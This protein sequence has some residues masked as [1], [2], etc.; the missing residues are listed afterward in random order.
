M[1]NLGCP[2]NGRDNGRDNGG[3]R[4]IEVR[5]REVPLYTSV[6]LVKVLVIVVNK[7]SFSYIHDVQCY[8][9]MV[10]LVLVARF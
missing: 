8:T 2:D 1:T 5:I 10:V 6:V 3:A 9:Y 7:K 4:I